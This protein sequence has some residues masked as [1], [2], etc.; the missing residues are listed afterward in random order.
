MTSLEDLLDDCPII[1]QREF[2]NIIAK[3]AERL[4]EERQ[5]PAAV[6]PSVQTTT[7]HTPITVSIDGDSCTADDLHQMRLAV[8]EILTTRPM[9]WVRNNVE[10]LRTLTEDEAIK[11]A[12]KIFGMLNGLLEN[13][14][15]VVRQADDYNKNITATTPAEPDESTSV[16]PRRRR[17]RTLEPVVDFYDDLEKKGLAKPTDYIVYYA[18]LVTLL[19]D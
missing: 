17:F 12:N 4:A 3:V 6:V 11:T 14:R 13:I 7:K 1:H 10:V 16:T 15:A 18:N 5:A 19:E 2:L 8:V 9:T